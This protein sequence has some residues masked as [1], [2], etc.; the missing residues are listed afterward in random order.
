M[1]IAIMGCGTVGTGVYEIIT[2]DVKNYARGAHGEKV[3]VKYIL[4][5]RPLA[6]PEMEALRTSRIEDIVN[7]PEV[8]VVVES[9]GG[10]RPSFEFCMQCLNAG[11]SVVTS[12]KLLVA[13]KGESLFA[14]AKAN[15]A[16]F[17]FGASVCGGVPV[18]RTLFYGLAANGINGFSGILNG[19][20]NYVLTKMKAEGAGFDEALSRAQELGYAEKDPTDDVNGADAA[21]KTAILASVCFGA[22]V[23]PARV[24]TEGITAISAEDVAYADAM[25]AKIKLIG[26]GERLPDGRVYVCVSPAVLKGSDILA[27]VD[28]VFNALTIRGSRIGEVMFYGPGA[29]KDATASAVV[30]DILDCLRAPGFDPAYCWE[31]AADGGLLPYDAYETALYVRGAARDAKKAAAVLRE[32]LGEITFLTRAGA[33]ESEIAFVTG[34]KP[35]KELRALLSDIPGFET[36]NTIRIRE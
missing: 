24:H 36:K 33:P 34:V 22:H 29:G 12:N 21:R 6:D 16:A 5:I 11:K 35:E 15:N 23:Y 8:Q 17:R 19:T 3:E 32:R 13:E 28:G 4:D 7:D 20:T 14:A 30:A 26:R 25:N 27:D 9:M 2:H 31:N 10:L 1:K 18:I